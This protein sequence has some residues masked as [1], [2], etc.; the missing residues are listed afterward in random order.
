MAYTNIDVYNL[1]KFLVQKEAVSGYININD[2]N[3]LLKQSSTLLLKNKL[4]IS[5]DY[6]L[7]AP[8][9]KKQKGVSTISD[10]EIKQFKAKTSLS[11]SSGIASLPANYFKYD[12]LR[13]S[14]ALEPVEV[15]SSGEL[16]KRLSDAIDAPDTDFPAAE[17]IGSSVY[18]YPTTITAASLIY[19]RYTNAPSLSYYVDADGEVVP[20][21]AGVTYMLQSGEIGS[22]GETAGNNIVSTT[23]EHEWGTECAV[24]LGYVIAKNLGVNI[25][26]ADVFQASDRIFKEGI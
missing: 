5:N 25:N 24:E 6:G 14:T 16:S 8:V 12:D 22:G 3:L 17:I 23:L 13:V 9:S 4:G 1:V 19:Y 2:F 26:R 7:L 11:F 15:L 20:L 18:I 21:A 10:D